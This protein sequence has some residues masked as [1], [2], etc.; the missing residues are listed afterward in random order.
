M[1]TIHGEEIDT[2]VP[3]LSTT[4]CI[5]LATGLNPQFFEAIVWRLWMSIKKKKQNPWT[6]KFLLQP[7]LGICFLI[8]TIYHIKQIY[9]K[10][11]FEALFIC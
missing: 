10:L 2:K 9:I 5:V 1:E 11:L 7:F 4:R 8:F 3:Y 6:P